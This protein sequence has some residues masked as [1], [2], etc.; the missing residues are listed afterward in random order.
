MP[1]RST[2]GDAGAGDTVG[3]PDPGNTSPRHDARRV[4]YRIDYFT[5]G[6]APGFFDQAA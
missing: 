4:D 1:R 5:A 6:Y 2:P 3:H